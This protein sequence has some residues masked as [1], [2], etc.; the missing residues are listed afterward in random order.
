MHSTHCVLAKS[1]TKVNTD[2]RNVLTGIALCYPHTLLVPDL[3]N[4]IGNVAVLLNFI[5]N[6]TF[7]WKGKLVSKLCNIR[8]H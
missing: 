7:S 2:Q 5:P 8:W 6:K 3:V 1:V 4:V